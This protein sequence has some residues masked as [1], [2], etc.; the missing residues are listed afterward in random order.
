VGTGY[1]IAVSP[2]TTSKYYA[3]I[4]GVEPTFCTAVDTVKVTVNQLPIVEISSSAQEICKGSPVTLTASGAS[5]YL[6]SNNETGSQ[7]TVNPLENTTYSVVGTS[8]FGCNSNAT[9]QIS[10]FPSSEVSISGLLPVYCQTDSPVTLIG[11]PDGGLFSGPGMIS[12]IFKPS[13]AGPGGHEIIYTYTNDFECVDKDTTNTFVIGFDM[14]I[15]IGSDSLICPANSITLDAG[16]GFS[17]YQWS[18]GQTTQQITIQGTSYQPGTSR[19]ISVVGILN[20]CVAAGSMN[21]TIKNDCYIGFSEI[22]DKKP[23]TIAPNP[24]TGSFKIKWNAPVKAVSLNLFDLKGQSLLQQNNIADLGIDQELSVVVPYS[25]KG[26]FLLY[27]Y[28][29]QSVYISKILVE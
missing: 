22:Q 29:D 28:V 15:D 13:I 12:N 9:I 20:G 8:S 26:L 18:T 14:V 24:S 3:R 23:Y 19:I 5:T 16:D 27:L 4:A 2:A 21:L 7:I 6:W 1:T 25:Q 11:Q 10:V 17:S